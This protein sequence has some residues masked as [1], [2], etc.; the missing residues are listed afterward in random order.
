MRGSK[1]GGGEEEGETGTAE[2]AEVESDFFKYRLRNSF[3]SEEKYK[4][5]SQN[6]L[7]E[8]IEHSAAKRIQ[9]TEG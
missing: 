5:R 6:E 8:A 7:N 2:D 9:S 1:G 3:Q 4:G